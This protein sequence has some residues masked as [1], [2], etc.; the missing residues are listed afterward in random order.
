[1]IALALAVI[2]A[3]YPSGGLPGWRTDQMSVHRRAVEIKTLG[4][5]RRAARGAW[6]R[7]PVTDLASDG[8]AAG[9]LGI[10][11]FA[12]KAEAYAISFAHLCAGAVEPLLAAVGLS[13][14]T[15][16][17][18]R[19]LDVGTGAGAVA[20]RVADRGGVVVAV[21]PDESMRRLAALAAPSVEILAGSLPGLPFDD[22]R[23]DVVLANFVVNHVGDPQAAVSDLARVAAGGGR[24]GVTIWPEDR[25]ALGAVW[26]GVAAAGDVTWP[27]EA[28]GPDVVRTPEGLAGLLQRAGLSDVEAGFLHWVTRID[29]ERLWDG[30]AAGVAGI[31]RLVAGRA[32]DVRARM[33]AAYDE[34]VEPLRDEDRLALPTIAVLATGTKL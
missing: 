7:C 5:S 2:L 23:F 13:P 25:G 14:E 30:V 12:G 24:V 11:K 31:G 15:A 1:M 22:G 33:R 26:S 3:T 18:R 34:L 10:Q 8:L 19:V 20:R 27:P 16:A 29:P 17:G 6:H 9:E 21:D 4:E 32:A 28:A